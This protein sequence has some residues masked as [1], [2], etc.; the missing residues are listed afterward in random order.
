MN[1][2]GT[3]VLLL[4]ATAGGCAVFDPA[5]MDGSDDSTVAVRVDGRTAKAKRL[6]NVGLRAMKHGKVDLA[7][8]KFISAVRADPM[9]GPAHNS[10]GLLHYD[11]GN[12]FQAILSFEKAMEAM[13]YHAA[14]CYNLALSLE[15][16]G[17]VYE[18]M[19]L[20]L[21][22]VEMEPANPHY[23]G[24]LV[25]LKVRLG[26]HDELLVHQLQNLVLIETRPEWRAW[27]DRQLA[28]PLNAMLDRGPESPDLD[29]VNSQRDQALDPE[30]IIN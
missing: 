30:G 24:S 7:T 1:R 20:Y 15:A 11:Q 18:A 4:L 22:A 2:C 21:Q 9:Y 8:T 29:E 19:D 23:L 25:R 26:E 3:I 28:L 6:T 5:G 16:A 27:A 14:A 13:P 17:R 12:L 10:L